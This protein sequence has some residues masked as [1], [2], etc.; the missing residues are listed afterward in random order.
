M[1]RQAT[2]GKWYP[3]PSTPRA[4][5]DRII[6]D[7]IYRLAEASNGSPDAAAKNTGM[8]LT[9]AFAGGFQVG[10]KTFYNMTFRDGILVGVS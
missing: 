10:G 1:P 9:V 7:H 6:F 2:E 8:T 5:T 3:T 4:D